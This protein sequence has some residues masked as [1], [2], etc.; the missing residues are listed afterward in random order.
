MLASA[1]QRIDT[2]MA[3]KGIATARTGSP[4]ADLLLLNMHSSSVR[5]ALKFCRTI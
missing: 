2:C 4:L 3:G 5:S 1:V